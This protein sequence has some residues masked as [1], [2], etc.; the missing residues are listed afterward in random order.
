MLSAWEGE[1]VGGDAGMLLAV[2]AATA[3]IGARA[4]IMSANN[5]RSGR[6]YEALFF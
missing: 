4:S 3:V 5:V 1:G 6:K 2:A